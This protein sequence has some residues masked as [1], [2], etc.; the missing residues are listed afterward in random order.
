MRPFERVIGELE[1]CDRQ[2]RYLGQAR[3]QAQCPAH[4]DR[5]PSLSITEQADGRVLVHCHAGCEIEDVLAA[6][7]LEKSDLFAYND[8]GHRDEE[9]V[10]RYLDESSKP[11]FE[12]V[13]FPGKRFAQRRPDGTWGLNGAR[14]VL[15]RLPK[16]REAAARGDKIY[17]VE[18]EK[19]VHALERIGVVAT[20]NPGGAG[21]WRKEY[22][23]ML[24]GAAVTVVAD[25][26]EP[27]RIHAH[28]VAESLQ[29]IA[30]EV[31]VVEPA[32]GKDISDHLAAG[33]V[34]DELQ[35][36][37]A[38]RGLAVAESISSLPFTLAGDVIANAPP[39]PDWIW[40]GYVAPGEVSL[41]AGRP[42]VGKSTLVFGLIAAILHGR[43]F[44]GRGTRGRGVLLLTEEGAT[45][46]A[47]KA[48]AFGIANHPRFHVLLRRRTQ[49]PWPEVVAQARAY[50]RQHD[51]DVVIVDTFDKWAGL[52]GDDE[53]KSGPMLQA[54]E[55][56]MVASGDGLA[57][58]VVSHQRKAAGD[59]GEAV[60][61][62]NALTGTVDV[63]VEIER[64][65]DV[66]HARALVGTSRH[67]STPEELAVELTDDGYVDR[68]DVDALK[69]RLE[70]DQIVAVLPTEPVTS[71]EI[72]EATEIPEATVRR[73]LDELHA[74]SRVE[75]TGEGRKGSPYRW[76]MLSATANPLVAERKNGGPPE[77]EAPDWVERLRAEYG[78]EAD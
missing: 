36:L 44:V 23:E 68:G 1:L 31:E 72:A 17:A 64:V 61:G 29:G 33:K 8:N 69:G 21:K 70:A 22:S 46:F 59:H 45:T 25:R 4:D 54:L 51:L 13:R 58:I 57:V 28:E 19:D 16:V 9:Q 62:S 10:Y 34:L 50:C 2:V 27:G 77:K 6:I 75:R 18:G 74:T 52:R 56:L 30:A 43:P 47:E 78:E 49:A 60:R 26:D 5:K 20:T 41:I 67:T 11:L 15:Y 65:P 55:P 40:D 76:K 12:V 63:I 37:S 38:T 7:G 53:N 42:K 66:A 73:R 71:K 3:A 32:E 48:R 35:I 14:R 24:R 39:E